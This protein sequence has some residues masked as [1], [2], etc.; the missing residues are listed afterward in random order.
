MLEVLIATTNPGKLREYREIFADLP[1]H[2]QSLRDVGLGDMDVEETGDTFAVNA[3]L[4]ARAYAQA[5]GLVTLADDSGLMIDALDGAPG[6]YSAR[7]AGPGVDDR[8]RIAKVLRELDGV[9]D[10][11]RTARFVCVTSVTLPHTGQ[12]ISTTGIVEGRISDVID[13]SGGGFG[14]DPIF[15]PDGYTIALSAVPAADKNRL[16]HRGRAAELMRPTLQRLA[17]EHGSSSL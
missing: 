7:Y 13:E 1:V 11:Q 8:T 3:E 17:E 12:T 6:L 2:L 14:Y 10:E 5:S 15:I 4:K 16:S 9:A